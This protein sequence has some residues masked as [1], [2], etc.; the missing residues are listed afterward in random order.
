MADDLF[1]PLEA[2]L[3]AVPLQQ[4]FS[5]AVYG[6]GLL[7]SL[8]SLRQNGVFTDVTLKADDK[9]ITCH[10]VVL[11][12]AS[13]YFMAMF[14][15][16]LEESCAD[17]VEIG[18]VDGTTLATIVD[19]IYSSDVDIT[20]DN[21]QDLI[22]A[23]ELLHFNGLKMACERYMLQQVAPSNCIGFYKFAKL[24]SLKFLRDGARRTMLTSFREVVAA[25][26]EFLD[27]AADEL[28]EYLSDDHLVVRTEDPLFEAVRIWYER[29]P[30][31]RRADLDLVLSQVRFPYCSSAY[32]CDVVERSKLFDASPACGQLLEEA[33]RY[34]LLP[35]RRHEMRGSRFVPRRSFASGRKLV[36]IGG[37]T[38]NEK[39]NRYCWYLREDTGSWE[40]LA[41]LPKPSW[42]FYGI[43]VVP[44]GIL[45]TG[46]YHSNVKRDCWLF[47]VT[48]K[49]WKAMPAM[50]TSRCKHRAVVHGDSVYVVGGEDD[51]DRPL[52]SVE[53]LNLRSRR[54]DPVADLDKA[55]SDPLVAAL[56]RHLY[57]F[58][59]IEQ[60][61]GTS[62]SSSA[63]DTVWED[64]SARADM[65]EQC[66]LGSVAA[67]NDRIYVLA[68][69]SH[70]CAVYDPDADSWTTLT[71]PK[72][73]H[74]NAPAVV[75]KGKILVGG[76]DLDLNETTSI[77][78]EYHPDQDEWAFWKL[79]L[80]EELSC[81]YLLNVDLDIS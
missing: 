28:V 56:G 3:D 53:R 81:H 67:L 70:T 12:A 73:K 14:T 50:L 19:Y 7:T 11:S 44:G 39:E 77:V 57:V 25:E 30:Q 36:L 78:E 61:D 27:M 16:G 8:L 41:Q 33:R 29:D 48:D 80:K 38:K 51:F 4:R 46:G 26:G 71:R 40:L 31:G 65:P 58:G 1:Y 45:M 43:C 22:Q 76:G 75:W 23:C 20:P 63:Y 72:E 21:V 18:G 52:N 35:E 59:G 15:S 34:Q 66:R 24:Y 9:E 79:P 68:G 55:V 2:P 5:D 47:D 17:V 10:R 64:W 32:L 54:W 42:K 62:V 69:Y 60:N 74:G 13:P 49:K 6:R 37:L